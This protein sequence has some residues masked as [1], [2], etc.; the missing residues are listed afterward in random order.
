MSTTKTKSWS[1]IEEKHREL[2]KLLQ[3]IDATSKSLDEQIKN[4]EEV[5]KWYLQDSI[6]DEEI[7]ARLALTIN[8][9]I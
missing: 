6:I 3:K 5:R 1:N 9:M 4:Y 7:L 2:G 8:N